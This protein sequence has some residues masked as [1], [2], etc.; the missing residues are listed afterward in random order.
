[1]LHA[2]IPFG[3]TVTYMTTCNDGLLIG[4]TSVT[5]FT[6]LKWTYGNLPYL[7]H[8]FPHIGQNVLGMASIVTPCLLGYSYVGQGF[9]ILFHGSSI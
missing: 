9:Q 8:V 3:G 6:M 7:M 5:G 4:V 2:Q 1:M